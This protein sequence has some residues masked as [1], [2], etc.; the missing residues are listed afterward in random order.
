M[1]T[2]ETELLNRMVALELEAMASINVHADAK[3]YFFHW[4]DSFPYFTNRIATSPRN[5]DGS[6]DLDFNNPLVIVRLVVAHVTEGFKGEPEEKLYEWGPIVA[7]YIERRSN[8]LQTSTPPYT[9]R[10]DNLRESRVTDNGGFRMFQDSGIGAAQVGRE[11][12]V[13]CIFDEHIEQ[14]YL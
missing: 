7:S 6:E 9:T 2:Y 11:I 1:P 13:Q 4:Q 10:M 3:P 5:N 12:Q 14:I 8:W